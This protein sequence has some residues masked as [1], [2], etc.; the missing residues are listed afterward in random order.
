MNKKIQ[1][2]LNQLVQISSQSRDAKGNNL[3]LDF[4]EEFL[5]PLKM[6]ITRIPSKEFGDCL[7]AETSV[8]REQDLKPMV[9]LG[10]T[11]TVKSV[12]EWVD[13]S[14]QIGMISE[15]EFAGPGAYDMKAGIVQI[16]S[17]LKEL[18]HEDLLETFPI[19]VILAP[20]EE[21][22]STFSTP[23]IDKGTQDADSAVI[24]E[25]GRKGKEEDSSKSMNAIVTSRKGRV[26]IKVKCLG[27]EGHAGNSPD[28]KQN[29][30]NAMFALGTQ[31]SDALG[32]M[33]N[34]GLSFN[35]GTVKGGTANNVRAGESTLTFEIRSPTTDLI[36]KA[37]KKIETLCQNHDWETLY[38]LETLTKALEENKES[39]ELFKTFQDA[40][41]KHNV[42]VIKSPRVGGLSQA[43]H[44]SAKVPIIDAV[45]A[46]GQGAHTFDEKVCLNDLNLKI[47]VTTDFIKMYF[48][49]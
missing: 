40:C 30:I 36:T 3:V 43:N 9:L 7:I 46:L 12:K 49:K 29:A 19:R 15:L 38:T 42:E 14:K 44:I 47:K 28:S 22:A 25:F 34:D 8:V 45:G 33:N 21:I 31:I 41:A 6:E 27:V 48:N 16:L 17:S 32:K 10:H 1:N 35:F 24:F 20:D 13:E 39:V 26:Q 11:D 2:I 37:T 23:I 5:T 18:H 4:V